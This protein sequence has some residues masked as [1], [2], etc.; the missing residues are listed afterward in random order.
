[1]PC[2]LTPCYP[3][4]VDEQGAPF[5]LG[6]AASAHQAGRSPQALGE[7]TISLDAAATLAEA[8]QQLAWKLQAVLGRALGSSRG[9]VSNDEDLDTLA[10]SLLD[11]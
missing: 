8:S 3:L 7:V 11:F 9:P 6:A 4:P 10:S 2:E 5:S 1:M